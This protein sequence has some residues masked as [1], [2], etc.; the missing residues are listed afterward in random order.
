MTGAER[1]NYND[2]SRTVLPGQFF[3]C[4]RTAE[5]LFRQRQHT[6]DFA[7]LLKNN[8]LTLYFSDLV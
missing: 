6:E 3:L 2:A 4:R 1:Y 8:D 5:K 7:F